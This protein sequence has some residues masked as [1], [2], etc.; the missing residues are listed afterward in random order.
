MDIERAKRMTA[1]PKRKR[2]KAKPTDVPPWE[3]ELSTWDR[4]RA[5]QAATDAPWD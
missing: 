1:K 5:D 3:A 4:I 2:R